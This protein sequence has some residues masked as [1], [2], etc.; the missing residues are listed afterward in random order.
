[1]VTN[2]NIRRVFDD[3]LRVT[4]AN[5]NAVLHMALSKCSLSD[6][7][8]YFIAHDDGKKV[9]SFRSPGPPNQPFDVEAGIFK[10]S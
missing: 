10:V 8:S 4:A 7:Q 1:M 6:D 5:P 9:L 3:F 2:V